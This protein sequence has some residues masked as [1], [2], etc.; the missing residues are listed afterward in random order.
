MKNIFKSLL[1]L[2]AVIASTAAIAAQG[3]D[4][5]IITLHSDAYN[6]IGETNQFS[7]LLS[8]TETEY[9]DIDFGA[10][11][12]E[13]I[14]EPATINTETGE[15]D[16]TWIPCRVTAEGYIK[17]YGDASKIDVIVADGGYFTSIDMEQCTNLE[18]LSLEHNS[19]QSLDL[20]GFNKL[21]AIYLS[22]NPFTPQT[23]VK[24]GPNKPD[25]QILELDIIDNI[26][27]EFNLSDYPAMVA[28]DGYHS[29]GLSQID[30]TG[31]P[32]LRVLSLEMTAVS[33]VDVSQNPE[34]MRLN[35]SETRVT[36]IDLSHNSKLQHLLAGHYSGSVNLGYRL[37][38][39]DLS[40]NPDLIILDLTNN[41]LTSVD[42]SHNPLLTNLTLKRNALTSLDLTANT[43][44]YSVNLMYNDFDFAT[45]PLPQQSWGEYFYTQNDLPVAR[46]LAIG[47]QLD[48]A[49]KVLR[50]GTETT[51]KVFEFPYD[52][53]PREVE[54]TLYSYADGKISF[55]SAPTD[56]VAVY[57]YNDIFNE[58]PLTT[59][60]FKVKSATEFGRPTEVTSLIIANEAPQ[61]VTLSVG[62]DGAT[63]G[64]P[65]SFFIRYPDGTTEQFTATSSSDPAVPNVTL[66]HGTTGNIG[67]MMPENEV[68]TSLS[69]QGITLYEA[70]VT[71]ATELRS[72]NLEGCSLY[73]IDL[74]Y[75]RCLTDLNLSHNNLSSVTLAGIYGNYEKN[76]L[77][78]VKASDNRLT[79][80]E[81]VA[82]Q[83]IRYL[84]LSNNQLESYTLKDFDGIEHL[85]LSGNNLSGT[86]SLVYQ[87]D[88]LTVDISGNS[89]TGLQLPEFTR[90]ESIDVSDNH[91]NFATLPLTSTLAGTYTYAPQKPYQIFE[92]APAVNL[93]PIAEAADGS[94]TTFEWVKTDGTPLVEGVDYHANE[95]G[96]RF[97]NT[98]VGT[99]FCRMTNPAFPAFNGN[100]IYT[101]TDMTIVGAPTT[102]VATFTTTE[103]A[104]DGEVTVAGRP[105]SALYIDWHGDR[106]EFIP[107][108]TGTT[109]ISYP[110]QQTY[111][112]ANVTVYT[113]D[114]PSEVTVFALYDVKLSTFDGSP[115]TGIQTLGLYNAAIGDGNFTF[116]ETNSMAEI[117]LMGN[118]LT[119]YP[120]EGRFPNLRMLN[121]SDN[122]LTSFDAS[123]FRSLTN[124]YI[125]SNQLT[126]LTLGNPYMWELAASFNELRSIDLSTTPSL[127]Q[128]YLDKNLLTT[129]NINPI[130]DILKNLS[131]TGNYFTFT[132]LPLPSSMPIIKS[133]SYG[134]QAPLQV[135]C[136]DGKVDLSSQAEV[137]GTPTE[138]YW[139]LG[140]AYLDP[141]T[142]NY[143]GEALIAD[144]EYTVSNGVTT[145]LT[146]M[147]D[148]VMC[149][150]ANA[151]LPNLALETELLTAVA[152]IDEVIAADPEAMVNVY[153]LS[154]VL[155]RE[156]VAVREATA[157]LKTGIYIVGSRKVLVK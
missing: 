98:S 77:T 106:T 95:S 85:N 59:A 47:S 101:T 46:S 73:T 70:D 113:Y 58:Y 111:A 62:L 64:N 79:E 13:V 52:N 144:D 133:Y 14:I 89:L 39:I 99:V 12:N 105:G 40:H 97:P 7:I 66:K 94:K 42:L 18:I 151:L 112:G 127:S 138:Y 49:T 126:S 25:L 51:A 50:Q 20:S 21:Q 114:D 38:S 78:T 26:D 29:L 116:P 35:I 128:L 130:A 72:L 53:E 145:F 91:L 87:A 10:G 124:L 31:C 27:P 32:N 33:S 107:Y 129:I 120:F 9:F 140:E 82:T 108:P 154:G 8:S 122:N 132:T 67:I 110:D 19:L 93:S 155:L 109:Y 147:P 17:I 2:W 65:H 63:P 152:S 16:G 4:T 100:D 37:N 3:S 15:W 125:A 24:I 1:C 141:E 88:A 36:D 137:A 75:N 41:G 148:K 90:I 74:K 84:D 43:E 61:P 142:G 22:D 30:P 134:Y 45:L 56:S 60:R 28:F 121:L 150:M 86:L 55:N 115:M 6:V 102:V 149:V 80:F 118:N 117:S 5:P 104:T 143:V 103:N 123:K 131:L 135:E 139:F 23:P 83:N 119:Y 11:M 34:L 136:V 146:D 81:I 92:Q 48:L 156:N 68:M 57:Y 71:N 76:V 153:T 54:P 96:F 69:A 157:G 44:L